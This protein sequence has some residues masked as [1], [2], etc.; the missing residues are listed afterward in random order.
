MGWSALH[1]PPRTTTP[2]SPSTWLH[3]NETPLDPYSS[4]NLVGS[5]IPTNFLEYWFKSPF[6]CSGFSIIWE[7]KVVL[8]FGFIPN[9]L[10]KCIKNA[11][12]TLVRHNHSRQ[13]MVPPPT[14]ENWLCGLQR[15]CGSTIGTMSVNLANRTTI[16]KMASYPCGS[17][18]LVMKSMHIQCYGPCGIG[19]GRKRPPCFW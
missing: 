4:P 18:K 10:V 7:W 3:F 14:F 15:C 13:P 8:N 16:T 19:N 2:W 6:T 9:F 1:K 12:W 17:G 5:Y 11:L